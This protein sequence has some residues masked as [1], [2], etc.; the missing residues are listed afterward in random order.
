VKVVSVAGVTEGKIA[1]NMVEVVG[2]G[3]Q[4]VLE[5]NRIV[6]VDKGVDSRQRN[7]GERILYK[8]LDRR[9]V[10]GLLDAELAVSLPPDGDARNGLQ[11]GAAPAVAVL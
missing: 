2:A 1:A 9:S 10:A 4:N 11:L 6:S 7:A 5:R 3:R 8:A